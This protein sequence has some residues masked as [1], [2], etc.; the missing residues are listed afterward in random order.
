MPSASP[1]SIVVRRISSNARM[2]PFSPRRAAAVA[3]SD[4][5]IDLP[6]P[7]GPVISVLVPRVSP[8]PSIESSAVTP[9]ETAVRSYGV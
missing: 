5:R 4:A 6:V 9:L 2:M 1:R 7:A 8:P 3:Y